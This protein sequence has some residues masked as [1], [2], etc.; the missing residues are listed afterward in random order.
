[1]TNEV[2]TSTHESGSNGAQNEY[3]SIFIRLGTTIG[4]GSCLENHGF[5]PFLSHLWS[6][7][8][9]FSRPLLALRGAKIAQHGLK[10]GSFH[11]FVHPK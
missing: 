6:Q 5:D 11:L 7:S 3:M 2:R 9:P 8:G 10:M 1:M 4:L